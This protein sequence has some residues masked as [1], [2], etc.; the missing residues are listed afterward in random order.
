MSEKHTTKELIEEI[1]ED[2][3]K[4]DWQIK[5]AIEMKS[6]DVLERFT[7]RKA[8]LTRIKE[9]L[10]QKEQTSEPVES[11]QPEQST[12]DKKLKALEG[13]SG[14]LNDLT[15]EQMKQFNDAVGRPSV[16]ITREELVEM[17][18]ET[19]WGHLDEEGWI[20]WLKSKGIPVIDKVKGE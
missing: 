1:N 14:L 5:T 15:P 8:K 4:T 3:G 13:I 7:K 19:S 6:K 17:C 11:R 10:E 9:I 12:I 20:T 16:T 2:I 18:D